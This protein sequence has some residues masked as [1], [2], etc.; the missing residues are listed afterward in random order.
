MREF[1]DYVIN[2]S[3]KA[4]A[5]GCMRVVKGRCAYPEKKLVLKGFPR[6]EYYPQGG[7]EHQQSIHHHNT[8]PQL[9]HTT[10]LRTAVTEECS[11]TFNRDFSLFCLR[12]EC[13]FVVYFWSTSFQHQIAPQMKVKVNECEPSA[14]T[15]NPKCTV[16]IQAS[17]LKRT[18][19]IQSSIA[20]VS[21]SSY[22]LLLCATILPSI[23]TKFK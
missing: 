9:H 21:G 14:F 6:L 4:A 18:P 8:E 22:I 13:K 10:T 12:V 2:K 7:R 16:C 20:H 23:S 17:L 11:T 19:E 15:T 5:T 1:L 3:V